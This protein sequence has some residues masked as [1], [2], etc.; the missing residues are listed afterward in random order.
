MAKRKLADVSLKK[1]MLLKRTAQSVDEYQAGI[2]QETNVKDLSEEQKAKIVYLSDEQLVDDPDNLEIYGQSDVE[3]LA[4]DMTLYG[5]QGVILAYKYGDLYRIESGHRRREAGRLAG[6]PQYPVFV[7]EAPETDWERILR[8][9]RANI[10]GR[11]YL[12]MVTAKM[13]QSL[14]EAHTEEVS[15]KKK[16]GLVEEGEVTSVNELVAQDLEIDSKTVSKYRALLNLIPELQELANDKVAWSALSSASTLDEARQREL[17]RLIEEKHDAENKYPDRNWIIRKSD[18]M[19]LEQASGAETQVQPE[20]AETVVK[21]RVRRKNGAKT[22]IST[23]KKLREVLDNDA[24]FKKDQ[25]PI[26]IETLENL[27]GS[28]EKKLEELQS[29]TK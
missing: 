10:H 13:A 9:N 11:K 7:T 22:V 8:L 18:V 17:L 19:K 5:F 26:V 4:K 12:P 15:Y 24:L 3:A 28:I 23:S 6:I 2:T 21:T 29:G 14:F 20:N 1:S 16:N 25:I 27:K